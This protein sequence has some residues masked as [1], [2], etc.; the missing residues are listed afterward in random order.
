MGASGGPRMGKITVCSTGF[1]GAGT[2]RETAVDVGGETV[3]DET[4][5]LATTP[6]DEDAISG[7]RLAGVPVDLSVVVLA[8]GDVTLSTPAVPTL[9]ATPPA[10]GDVDCE[11]GDAEVL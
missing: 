9:V 6:A 3:E 11:G 4:A 8:V 1:G 2:G 5:T 10:F 7:D